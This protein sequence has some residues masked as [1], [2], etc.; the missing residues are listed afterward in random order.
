MV[1]RDGLTRLRHFGTSERDRDGKR[2]GSG[3]SVTSRR[4]G[5]PGPGPDRARLSLSLTGRPAYRTAYRGAR[6][7]YGTRPGGYYRGRLW[8][9]TT[10]GT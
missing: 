5:M 8:Y 4:S 6:P 7:R 2:P 1:R 3:D 9:G 10:V